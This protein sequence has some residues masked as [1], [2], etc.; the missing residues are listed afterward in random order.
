MAKAVYEQ[1]VVGEWYAPTKRH[2]E[3]CCF[4]GARHEIEYRI[5]GGQIEVRVVKVQKPRKRA[6]S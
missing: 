4:C 6:G 5:N 3:K 1:V 2:S